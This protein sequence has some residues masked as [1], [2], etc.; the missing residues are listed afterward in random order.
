M[1][2]YYMKLNDFVLSESK[3]RT[4][5]E[6]VKKAGEVPAKKGNEKRLKQLEKSMDKVSLFYL[7]PKYWEGFKEGQ[8]QCGDTVT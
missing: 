8:G 5:E 4:S 7:V 3:Y 2:S 6:N 1:R